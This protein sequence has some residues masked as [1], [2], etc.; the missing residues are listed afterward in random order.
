M[1]AK[2]TLFGRRTFSSWLIENVGSVPVKRRMDDPHGENDN[3]LA[4]NSL[5]QVRAGVYGKYIFLLELIWPFL[6]Q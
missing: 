2:S 1:T 3:T 4:M 6:L 5:I